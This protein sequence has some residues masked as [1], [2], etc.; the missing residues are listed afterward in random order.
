MG[1]VDGDRNGDE[2]K[3]T[4]TGGPRAQVDNT[5]ATNV[6]PPFCELSFTQ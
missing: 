2:S 3:G 6:S 4:E 1:V 5:G